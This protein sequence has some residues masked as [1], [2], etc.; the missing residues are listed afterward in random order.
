MDSIKHG[1]KVIG[2]YSVRNSHGRTEYAINLS[3]AMAGL[4]KDKVLFINMDQ[5]C[6]AKLNPNIGIDFLNPGRIR[7]QD[8]NDVK[9][10]YSYIVV[11]LSSEVNSI[12]ELQGSFDSIHFFVES[13]R[14]SLD[15]ARKFLE[16]L[17]KDGASEAH[18]KMKMVVS[19]LDIFD[20]FSLEE[21]SWLIRRDVW[22]ILP[23]S[24]ILEPSVGPEGIPVVVKAHSSEYAKAI[25]RIAKKE[26]GRLLG[27]ALG[28]GAAFGIA[29]IGVFR[30]L[31]KNNIP[32]D[33]MSGSSIG[34]LMASM[35]GLGMSSDEIERIAG[36]LKSKLNVMKLLD[37]G[38]PIS[39]ILIGRRLKKFIRSF[40]G[41]KTFEDLKIPVKIMVYDLANRQTFAVE[42]GLLVEAVYMS[43]AV[44]GIFKPKVDHGRVMV[45][46]GISDP[47]PV[48]ALLK[49]G[50]KKIIAV[51]VMPGPEDIYERN[52]A[53]RKRAEREKK[54][55]REGSFYVKAR[56]GLRNALRK[57]L[58]PNIFDVI[59][60]SIQSMEYMLAENS[61]K[62]A[63]VVLRPVFFDAE[64]TD[65]YRVEDFVKQ[66][67]KETLSHIEEI[68]ALAEI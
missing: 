2:V 5:S 28:S 17:I 6:K 11:N 7:K 3:A 44:P 37:F 31:E 65:F 1:K 55:M 64:A 58:T 27:L 36:K 47:V 19:R 8:I 10:D 66:G 9:K 24:G 34:A 14:S 63:N 61:C 52:M 26:T 16:E 15:S 68:K 12:N 62:K 35:W 50:V 45:D 49:Q 29:H 67:E 41:E 60:T 43:I 39:G 33:I 54:A 30:V 42:K 48:G 32:I 13:E 56:L 57:L 40:L 21:I 53:L 20:R 22:D 46:G 18:D 4:I 51:N 23:E 59:M 25:L 38:M